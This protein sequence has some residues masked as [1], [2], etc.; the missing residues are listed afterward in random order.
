MP[1]LEIV[2]R[3]A[4]RRKQPLH[5]RTILLIVLLERRLHHRV[6]FG[7]FLLNL[8][9]IAEGLVVLLARRQQVH[10]IRLRLLCLVC[11]VRRR[12]KSLGGVVGGSLKQVSVSHITL[13]DFAEYSE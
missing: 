8:G 7:L 9:Q 2:D 13:S 10:L 6:G 3:R 12:Q 4:L 1:R 5:P 11:N